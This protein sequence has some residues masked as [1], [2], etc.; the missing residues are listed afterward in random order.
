MRRKG[1]RE[2][3][4]R[5]LVAAAIELIRQE[6]A[7]QLTTTAVTARAG[8]TQ[9]GFYH[10]FKDIEDCKRA[11]AQRI[12]VEVRQFVADYRRR[13]GPEAAADPTVINDRHEAILRLFLYEGRFAELLLRFRHDPSPLGKV[14]RE[15]I[16]Q[17]RGDLVDDLRQLVLRI[18]PGAADDR[19]FWVFARFVVG[20]CCGFGGRVLYGWLC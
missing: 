7:E 5:R 4:H 3:T 20:V 1:I 9:S 19:R 13:G 6:G 14:L 15:L 17:L 8:I 10:Y 16:D 11:A 12:A 2:E 18:A